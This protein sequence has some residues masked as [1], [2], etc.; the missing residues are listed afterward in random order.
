MAN[1]LNNRQ[2]GFTL[3]EVMLALVLIAFFAVIATSRQPSM[4]VTIKAQQG[5]FK[6]RILL[7]QTRAMNTDTEW[8]IGLGKCG[9]ADTE[10]HC[11]WMFKKTTDSEQN[12]LIPGEDQTIVNLEE[13]N[14]SLAAM[15]NETE[16]KAVYFD[17]WGQPSYSSTDNSTGLMTSEPMM[18]TL[19]GVDS[20]A[21][22]SISAKTGFLQ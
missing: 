12:V 4:D 15:I 22:I 10:Q 20:T 1:N 2:A 6:S 3:F 17:S 8:G 13:K 7:A 14:I 5:S 18:I 19:T 11:Y 21:T 9:E 16:I